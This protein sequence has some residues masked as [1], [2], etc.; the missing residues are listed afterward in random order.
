MCSGQEDPRK[1]GSAMVAN[2]SNALATDVL[3][4]K[5]T[6]NAISRA[7]IKPYQVK[8]SVEAIFE[9]VNQVNACLSDDTMCGD[10]LLKEVKLPSWVKPFI[11][12][13]KVEI[14]SSYFATDLV[15]RPEKD[16]DFH[17]DAMRVA[18][19]AN[20]MSRLIKTSPTMLTAEE[21]R[22]AETTLS[23]INFC[24]GDDT[25]ET[26]SDAFIPVP[27]SDEVSAALGEI[28]NSTVDKVVRKYFA[29]TNIIG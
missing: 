24:V 25:V 21:L 2:I 16:L 4:A 20:C 5:V 22:G 3:V 29:V 23:S 6:D 10:T 15:V 13:K 8:E 18:N 9:V 28:W 1:E 12:P 26:D 11:Y 19:A 7:Q 14:Y 17:Y 27:I